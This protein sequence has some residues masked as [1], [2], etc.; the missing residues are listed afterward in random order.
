MLIAQRPT[1]S[2]E[3]VDEFRS[4][5]VIE[6][7]EPGFGYTLG[8]S[9]RRTLLSSIPGASVTSIKIDSVLH[10]FSTIEGV[11]ED[12]T[13]LI[14][15]LKGLV[16]SSEHD[17][18]V[19]MYLRKSGAGDVTAADIAPPAGVEV[20]NPDLHIAT[21]NGKGRLEVELGS[22]PLQQPGALLEHQLG[23]DPGG[24]LDRGVVRPRAVGVRPAFDAIA[25]QPR[26]V[27]GDLRLPVVETG[28]GAGHRDVGDGS[29]GVGHDDAGVDRVVPLAE[30][31]GAHLERLGH[32]ALGGQRAPVDGRTDVLDGDAT[33]RSGLGRAGAGLG[34][35]GGQSVRTLLL[36]SHV[37]DA[38]RSGQG[39]APR[40]RRWVR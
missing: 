5:F 16:V 15:N 20:H 13:E 23:V 38:T 9:L 4:R 25:P 7:L 19:T 34:G 6:P 14:L 28:V 31:R 21:L 37:A 2:E 24:H 33:D 36:L 29:V 27:G 18:P 10:E 12:V 32:D 17:E 8:N 35:R 26:A 1:L 30:D 11:K 3:T 40:S 22:E 39:T